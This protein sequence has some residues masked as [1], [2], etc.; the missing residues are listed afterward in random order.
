MGKMTVLPASFTRRRRYMLQNYHDAILLCCNKKFIGASY[1][2][3][4]LPYSSS[5]LGISL[6]FQ[7]SIVCG[8]FDPVF[9]EAL[10]GIL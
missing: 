8:H 9:I 10:K 6:A 7:Y 2:L 1:V 3:C 5:I 4:S